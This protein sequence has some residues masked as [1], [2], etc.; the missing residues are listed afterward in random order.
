[1]I[2]SV[3]YMFRCPSYLC[4]R[5]SKGVLGYRVRHEGSPEVW[6]GADERPKRKRRGAKQT[7]E[8]AHPSSGSLLHSIYRDAE[9]CRAHGCRS[10]DWFSIYGNSQIENM[11]EN[12]ESISEF[13]NHPI[14]VLKQCHGKKVQQKA[15]GGNKGEQKP[16]G[17][18]SKYADITFHVMGR[19]GRVCKCGLHILRLKSGKNP[20]RPFS[21]HIGKDFS[22]CKGPGNCETVLFFC[23]LWIFV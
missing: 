16:T 22:A 12:I 5:S 8:R 19:T 6:D 11:L 4:S 10:C 15:L 13:L 21:N 23:F 18:R 1:M 20:W 7:G 2:H 14:S 9:S 3:W 17:R